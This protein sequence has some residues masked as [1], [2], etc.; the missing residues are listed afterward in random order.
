MVRDGIVAALD[1]GTTKV[2]CFIAELNESGQL[3]VTGIGHHASAGVKAGSIVNMETAETSI[4]AAVHA[5][6]KMAGITIRQVVASIS[7]GR[8]TS[9]AIERK[10]SIGNSAI[11]DDDMRRLF[12][13]IRL[14]QLEPHRVLVHVIPTAYGI[15]G[16]N[17]IRDPRGL[18]G[19]TLGVNLHL[20]TIDE[21]A[22][23]NLDTG[24]SRC[25][26][27]LS[28]LVIS[29]YASGLACLV[30]DE[31]NLG[32]TVIDMGGGMTTIAV[33]YDGSAVFTDSIPFGGANVTND[34]ARGLSTSVA[35]AERLKTLHGNVLLSTND[36]REIINAPQIGDDADS[37][38]SNVPKSLLVGIIAPRI[39]EIL[40]LVRARLVASGLE[41][42]VGRRVVL[43]GG[44]SQLPG[45]RELATQILDKQIRLGRPIRVNGL[46]DATGG[47]AFST[48]AGLLV[49]AADRH[50][51]MPSIL[52]R[53]YEVSGGLF[54][55]LGGWF[56]ENF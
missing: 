31:M 19:M 1:V 13:D 7:G 48:A 12:N 33:F 18:H 3:R 42:T 51:E 24:I 45:M 44:A 53:N 35:N 47:P 28:E 41:K 29:P 54:N 56:R 30:E 37:H 26:L 10:L 32:A 34:I 49:Y 14:L 36:E 52:A 2:C 21:S 23:R 46:A 55:R 38:A 39:E 6:E 16:S 4:R 22:A 17:G 9:N 25:H 20:V 5:A 11:S 27:D 50:N 15:D 40:E 8:P 43:T